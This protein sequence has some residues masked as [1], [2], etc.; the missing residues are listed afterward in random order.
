MGS[1]YIVAANV[2]MEIHLKYPLI[3]TYCLY[4][5]T[6]TDLLHY[7]FIFSAEIGHI[8]FVSGYLTY[9]YCGFL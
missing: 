4:S 9:R 8:F 1:N 6:Y 3:H 5:Y 7:L 2:H